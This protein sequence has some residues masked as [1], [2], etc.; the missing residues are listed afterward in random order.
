M[1]GSSNGSNIVNNQL[2]VNPN[3]QSNLVANSTTNSTGN[4]GPG[5]NNSNNN[6]NT[7]VGLSTSGLLS[8]N[9]SD[10]ISNSAASGSNA[11]DHKLTDELV[12]LAT[13]DDLLKSHMDSSDTFSLSP[14]GSSIVKSEFGTFFYTFKPI[15]R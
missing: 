1:N 4:L 5:S 2:A 14:N 15:D 6:T 10:L 9:E 3:S 13:G 12:S 8:G 7:S 11:P